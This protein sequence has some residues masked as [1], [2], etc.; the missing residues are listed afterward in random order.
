MNSGRVLAGTEG[1][2]FDDVGDADD[3]GDR[4][5]IADEIVIEL[6]V[7]RRV[8]RMNQID[9]QQRVA[10]GR[11]VH[12][13]FGA[14]VGAAAGPVLDNELL[15]EVLGQ[16]LSHQARYN[17]SPPASCNRNDDADRPRRIGLRPCNS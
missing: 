16:P 5:D 11:R 13:H 2:I 6:F 14:D 9:L 3:A 10:I 12:D 17:V 8:D 4:G 7:K 15:P 1:W